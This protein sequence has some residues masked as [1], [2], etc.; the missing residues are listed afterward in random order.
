MKYIYLLTALSIS[1][2]A[3]SQPASKSSDRGFWSNFCELLSVIF[4]ERNYTSNNVST[5]SNTASSYNYSTTSSSKLSYSDA[6]DYIRKV[7]NKLD[8]GFFMHMDYSERRA[9]EKTIDAMVQ[10]GDV[11]TKEKIDLL[12]ASALITYI[13]ETAYSLAYKKTSD[14]SIANRI[15]DSIRNNAQARMQ[16][17]GFLDTNAMSSFVGRKLEEA[18]TDA[19]QQLTPKPTVPS[20]PEYPSEECMVCYE[21]FDKNHQRIFLRPCG[22]D[23][24]RDCAQAHFVAYHNTTCPKCRGVVNQQASFKGYF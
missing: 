14:S 10:Q 24:C 21:S 16:N 23:M 9:L 19:A 17:Y 20:Y 1:S 5:Q 2:F 3:F 8:D 18:V 4:D 12:V 7:K 22:H 6:R 15:A 13:E 11:S